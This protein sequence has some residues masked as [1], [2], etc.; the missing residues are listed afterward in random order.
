MDHTDISRAK[1]DLARLRAVI[2]DRSHWVIATDDS[3]A[4]QALRGLAALL[5]MQGASESDVLFVSAHAVSPRRFARIEFTAV[6][7]AKSVAP[8]DDVAT[9]VGAFSGRGPAQARA[10][11]RHG[12]DIF[13][14]ATNSD[15]LV[16]CIDQV[17]AGSVRVYDTSA[18]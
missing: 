15:A 3:R 6:A 2:N 9:F 10:S 11:M 12:G 8:A 4:A 14:I 13:P 5:T 16:L 18:N 1:V 7:L 17:A